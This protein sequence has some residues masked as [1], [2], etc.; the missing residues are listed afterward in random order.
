MPGKYTAIIS[1]HGIGRHRHYAN[2]GA[3]LTAL[4]TVARDGKNEAL[5]QVDAG[6]EPPRDDN[7]KSDVPFL[8]FRHAK[9]LSKNEV[10]P[11]R[12]FRI[13]E[14]SW[15]PETKKRLSI[16]HMLSWTI[17]L[18]VSVFRLEPRSWLAWPRLRL[19][20]LRF[21]Y[22]NP[23]IGGHP[24]TV[25]ASAYRTYR[26]SLGAELRKTKDNT[27][28][29]SDF[30][31]YAEH[32]GGA[33]APVQALRDAAAIWRNT[34]L[35]CEVSTRRAGLWVLLAILLLALA[36]SLLTTMFW[37]NAELESARRI[38]RF[39]LIAIAAIGATFVSRFLTIVLSD[40]RYWSALNENDRYSETRDAVLVHA[41]ATLRHVVSDP[42]CTRVVI[43]SH[44]LG[45]AIAYDAL[46]AI[47]LHNRAR[48]D[49]VADQIEVRKVD[50]VVTMGSPIDKLAY[51]FET[52]RGRSFR[53]ELMREELRGDTTK[54]PFWIKGKQR[55]SWLNFWDPADAV[56]DPIY[57]P[58][59]AKPF[60]DRFEGTKIENIR[61]HNAHAFDPVGSHV[62]YLSNFA[63]ARRIYNEIFRPSESGTSLKK[64]A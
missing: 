61:V 17:T 50:C 52:S 51:L 60:G 37:G 4:E 64:N 26:G 47:G 41:T 56:S 20:R 44:S 11:G 2:A 15:S 1:V 54:G 13:Y 14:V 53:E 35:P 36:A 18:L 30:V 25:L 34:R 12:E 28:D 46:R 48:E 9:R 40:V 59:G 32:R 45:T 23:S 42:A 10:E 6:L 27:S 7:L 21:A 31:A 57:S 62:R 8:R 43:V 49:T 16:L 55:I 39:V 24:F 19:G 33:A 29:F 3:L 58:L 22:E 38:M 5:I 63:V